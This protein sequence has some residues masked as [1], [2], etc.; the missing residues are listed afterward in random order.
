MNEQVR[1][2]DLRPVERREPTQAAEGLPRWR[3]TTAE[4][5]AI[6]ALGL[7]G[8]RDPFELIGGEMVPMSP[9]GRRHELVR[10]ELAKVLRRLMP[11]SLDIVEETQLNLAPDTYTDPDIIV[12]PASIRAPDAMGKDLLLLI[13]I[14]DSSKAYD[15]GRKPHIYAAHGVREYWVVEAWSLATTV[16]RALGLHGYGTV[17][18]APCDAA[19]TSEALPGVVLRLDSLDLG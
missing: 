1:I 19:L 12:L 6:A 13:E 7:F 8:E 18:A 3:W 17:E 16:H 11:G 9:K 10:I 15:L 14:A 2:Q 4:L 5:E